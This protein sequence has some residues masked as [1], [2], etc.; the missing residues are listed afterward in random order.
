MTIPLPLSVT[1]L[2]HSFKGLG[3]N[4]IQNSPFVGWV[5]EKEHM[6]STK[7]EKNPVLELTPG[8]PEIKKKKKK[9]PWRADFELWLIST[10]V[11]IV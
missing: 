6:V 10:K 3:K 5:G 8:K 4:W 7:P 2:A 1:E 9:D 11:V